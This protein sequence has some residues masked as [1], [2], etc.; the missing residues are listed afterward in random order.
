MSLRIVDAS[1]YVQRV[2]N[3]DFDAV[4]GGFAQSNSPGNEQRDYWSTKAADLPGSRNIAG[5]KDP[6]VDAL[7]DKIIFAESREELVATTHALDR[8][9]LWNYYTVPQYYQPTMRFVY[10]NKFGIPE[11][12]PSYIGVDIDSWWIET[13]KAAN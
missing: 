12:Q 11:E 6:V 1:Q 7:V 3:F 2:Q 9:L 4:T 5:I 8:V 10:W 13:E